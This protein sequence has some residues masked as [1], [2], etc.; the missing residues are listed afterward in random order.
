MNN[1]KYLAWLT[2]IVAVL[3]VGASVYAFIRN[4]LS[5]SD[6]SGAVGPLAGTLVGYW[7]RGEKSE[8]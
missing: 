2:A 5:W 1:S 6:F 7:I 3:Y 4:S 8:S